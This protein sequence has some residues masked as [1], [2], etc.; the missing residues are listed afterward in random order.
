LSVSDNKI[1]IE[2]Y[3]SSS[4]NKLHLLGVCRTRLPHKYRFYSKY[5]VGRYLDKKK[6]EEARKEKYMRNMDTRLVR[7]MAKLR[8]EEAI[9]EMT[10]LASDKVSLR[11]LKTRKDQDIRNIK[12]MLIPK[13]HEIDKK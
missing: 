11:K 5:G 4:R 10:W 8:L 12:I 7:S 2:G 13:M 1:K 3:F 9:M 6:S